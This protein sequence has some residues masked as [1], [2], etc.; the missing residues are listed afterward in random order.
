MGNAVSKGALGTKVLDTPKGAG[1]LAARNG[2]APVTVG[3]GPP[4]SVKSQKEPLARPAHQHKSPGWF[5]NTEGLPLMSLKYPASF[6]DKPLE[7]QSL[8]PTE[9]SSRAPS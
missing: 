6:Q 1:L 7:R 2:A 3:P 8:E 4:L 9:G 5:E